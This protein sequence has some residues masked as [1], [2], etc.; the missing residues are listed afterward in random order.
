MG[1]FS[2]K[3]QIFLFASNAL[4]KKLAVRYTGQK[5]R[6]SLAGIHPPTG[7]QPPKSWGLG[8]G[9]GGWGLRKKT[10]F[11]GLGGLRGFGREFGFGW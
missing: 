10:T 2:N 11:R 1:G 6:I 8:V 4:E 5:P 3:N 9:V 7:R